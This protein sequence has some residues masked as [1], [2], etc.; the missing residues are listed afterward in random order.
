LIGCFAAIRTAQK[1]L[2]VDEAPRSETQL[3]RVMLMLEQ[4]QHGQEL[5]VEHIDLRFDAMERRFEDRVVSIERRL[6]DVWNAVQMHSLKISPLTE[7]TALN[8]DQLAAHGREIGEL[9]AQLR[10]EALTQDTAFQANP[11]SAALEV[12]MA[13]RERVDA[14]EARVAELEREIGIEPK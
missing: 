7:Q 11:P 1:H 9:R 6:D 13:S 14:I 12:M 10:A 5:I 3:G 4:I 8:T 2:M